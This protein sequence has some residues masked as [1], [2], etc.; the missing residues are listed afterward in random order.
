MY[1]C[2]SAAIGL[3]GNN[4]VRR[5]GNSAGVCFNEAESREFAK[6]KL[7]SCRL[8]RVPPTALLYDAS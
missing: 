2:A 8:A 5:D 7:D 3:F 4:V 6:D 1:A